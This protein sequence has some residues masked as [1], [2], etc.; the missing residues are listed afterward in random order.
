MLTSISEDDERRKTKF[1]YETR[2]YNQHRDNV[3][4][5]SKNS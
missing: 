5:H 2:F 4:E 3:F 1:N